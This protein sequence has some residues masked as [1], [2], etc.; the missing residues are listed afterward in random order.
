MPVMQIAKVA[1]NSGREQGTRWSA[2]HHKPDG[3]YEEKR[4]QRDRKDDLQGLDDMVTDAEGHLIEEEPSKPKRIGRTTR[5]STG[6]VD[7]ATNGSDTNDRGT[8][9]HNHEAHHQSHVQDYPLSDSEALAADRT[10]QDDMVTAA[11]GHLFDMETEAEG[12]LMDDSRSIRRSEVRVTQDD[13]PVE[14]VKDRPVHA[15]QRPELGGPAHKEQQPLT[16]VNASPL[17]H[18]SSSKVPNCSGGTAPTVPVIT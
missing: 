7:S 6:Y 15:E 16:P 4:C 2:E 11:E 13:Q 3:Q 12:H 1:D 17:D 9:T 8:Q 10:T 18:S 5:C 14:T